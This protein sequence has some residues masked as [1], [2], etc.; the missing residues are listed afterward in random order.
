M[1]NWLADKIKTW[2]RSKRNSYSHD[3]S[4]PVERRK[5]KQYVDWHDHGILRYRWH[6]FGEIA[7]GVYRSN[8]PNHERF[9][10]YAK[11]GVRTVLNLRGANNWAFYKFEAESCAALGMTLIDLPMVARSAPSRD[12]LL[13]LMTL[14]ETLEHPLL[15]HC[16]SGADRTGTAAAVYR[17][18]ILKQ[19]VA[20]AKKELS[21]RYV[22]LLFSKTGV[23]D[24]VIALYEARLA[25]G[26][27]SFHDWVANEYDRDAAQHSFDNRKSRFRVGP[28]A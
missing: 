1:G 10:T 22:H 14:F 21:L 17:L 3:I 11:M 12:V 27:I 19:P 8:Q 2:E 16:K 25:E 24:H 20:Q 23:Q 28:N 6:N 26:D 7:T 4:D 5:S 13:K 15:L 9:E 18:H